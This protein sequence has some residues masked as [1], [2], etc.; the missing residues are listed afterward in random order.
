MPRSLSK[1]RHN[2]REGTSA[3]HTG[4]ASFFKQTSDISH[5]KEQAHCTL[6]M[7]RF[8]SKDTSQATK[9]PSPLNE[10]HLSTRQLHPSTRIGRYWTTLKGLLGIE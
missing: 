1:D 5:A 9:F 4:Y 7:P 2:S 3:L 10:M 8:L 6:C